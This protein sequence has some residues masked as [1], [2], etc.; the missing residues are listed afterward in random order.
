LLESLAIRFSNALITH[1]S[2]HL[3]ELARHLPSGIIRRF[4][5]VEHAVPG[6]LIETLQ[7]NQSSTCDPR[8]KFLYVGRFEARK[9]LDILVEAI[10]LVT[11]HL[12]NCEFHIVGSDT[13]DC[14]VLSETHKDILLSSPNVF[15]LGQLS[16]ADL[17]L[18]Y[19]K[20][21]ILVFPSRYESFGLV[22]AEAMS[23]G[24]P[25]IA[26]R[27]GGVP[28]VIE[29]GVSG[30]LVDSIDS[31]S[32]ANAMVCLARNPA[33]LKKLSEGATAAYL[34]RFTSSI[35]AANSLCLYK[36]LRHSVNGHG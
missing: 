17:Q 15:L 36:S 25:S 21:D 32:L 24:L 28:S 7:V 3:G 19:Q 6:P 27:V 23:Y 34:S 8:V 5:I 16:Y 1:S 12:E 14:E 31:H 10:S 11:S 30:L 33:F 2:F 22:I 9:G 26:F 35:L 4:S 13:L 20:C 18:C 29:N